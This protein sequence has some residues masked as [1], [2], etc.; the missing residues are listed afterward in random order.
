MSSLTIHA[1]SGRLSL[2]ALPLL[3]AALLP[4]PASGAA[5]GELEKVGEARLKVMF[6]SIYDSRLYMPDGRYEPGKRPLRLEL[7]YLR[8]IPSQEL[9]KRTGKEWD[10]L[11]VPKEKQEGWMKKL[12]GLW[13]DINENDVLTLD[14]D[15]DN[16]ASFHHNG[17]YLGTIED[18]EFGQNFIDIWLSPEGSRPEMRTALI[19]N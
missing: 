5:E 1:S 4:A 17:D 15:A 12:Q 7:Q 14:L 18:A 19:G 16:H 9:V 13:P 6:W 10:G 2:F 11:G 8:D 3:L